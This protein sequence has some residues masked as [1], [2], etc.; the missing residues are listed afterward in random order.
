MY[1]VEDLDRAVWKWWLTAGEDE[2]DDPKSRDSL[3]EE[4]FD[5]SDFMPWY[6]L[7]EKLYVSHFG[8]SAGVVPTVELPGIGVLTQVE[9]YGGEGKGDDYYLIFKVVT[10]TPNT[11]TTRVFK[12]N[13]WHASHDGSY[14]EGPT[15]EGKQVVKTVTVFEEDK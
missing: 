2:L 6:E 7:G 5:S 9:S 10:R 1:T 13:G 3:T 14:L 15:V 11:K 4:D 8:D 12:R